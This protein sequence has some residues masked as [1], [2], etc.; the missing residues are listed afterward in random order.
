LENDFPTIDQA[1]GLDRWPAGQVPYLFGARF[2]QYLARQFG[3][4][5]PT[6]IGRQY[7]DRPGVLRRLHRETILG[8]TYRQLWDNWRSL[9]AQRFDAQRAD[10]AADGLTA[11]T[12]VTARGGMIFG[13]AVSPDGSTIAYTENSLDAF[14]TLRTVRID[15]TGDRMVTRRNSGFHAGWSPDGKTIAFA[16]VELW[17]NYSLYSDIYLADVAR[18]PRVGSTHGRARGSRVLAGRQDSSCSS[19]MISARAGSRRSPR[20]RR[21]PSTHGLDR[22]DPVR[23][24][25]WSPDGRSIALA[26]WTEGRQDIACSTSTHSPADDHATARRT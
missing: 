2:Y 6:E 23:H 12:T 13:P 26:V 18:E 16:Q 9:L 7:A 21:H 17:K 10:I 3:E 20:H 5:V 11:T 22:S 24:A 4:H 1:D 25:A 14:P 15:G 8:M 19:A